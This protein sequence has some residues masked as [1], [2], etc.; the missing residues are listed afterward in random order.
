MGDEDTAVNTARSLIKAAFID[1]YRNE[2]DRAEKC[3]RDLTD[4]FG[5]RGNTP[6]ALNAAIL[7]RI[8]SHYSRKP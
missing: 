6:E 1:Y 4:L 8:I 7:E 5:E 3:L 2:R